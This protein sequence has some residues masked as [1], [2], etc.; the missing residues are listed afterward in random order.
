MAVTIST[1]VKGAFNAITEFAFTTA[2]TAADGIDLLYQKRA[3]SMS[4][5]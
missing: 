3:M 2:T 4:Q 1:P 5:F